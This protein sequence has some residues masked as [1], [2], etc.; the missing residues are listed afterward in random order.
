MAYIYQL[1]FMN[2]FWTIVNETHFC[3]NS[4]TFHSFVNTYID[5][6]EH[7]LIMENARHEIESI[8]NQTLLLLILQ[9]VTELYIFFFVL[10]PADNF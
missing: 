9:A 10:V 1:N 5:I 8:A 4:A 3:F 7:L 6:V 2:Y